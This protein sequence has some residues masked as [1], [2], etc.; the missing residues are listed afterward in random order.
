MDVQIDGG[1]I[2]D[3]ELEERLLGLP[4]RIEDCELAELANAINLRDAEEALKEREAELLTSGQVSGSNETAR[5]AALLMETGAE[6]RA[7][8]A[9][10]EA[11][12]RARI[13]KRLRENEFSALRAVSRI[14]GARLR[15][16]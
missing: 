1:L 13:A 10:Q 8:N 6:R 16:V 15:V 5:K 14:R 7:V 12:D 4:D 11:L 9:A 3:A 2:S